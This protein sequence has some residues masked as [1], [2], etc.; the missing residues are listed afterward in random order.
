MDP[1]RLLTYE[2]PVKL[3]DPTQLLNAKNWIRQNIARD[4]QGFIPYTHVE[5]VF[6]FSYSKDAVAFALKWA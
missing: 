2:Y 6:Y 4:P 5:Y 3:N 1:D